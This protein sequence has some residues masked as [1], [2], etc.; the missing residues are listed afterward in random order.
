M[1][2]ITDPLF[3]V[4]AVPAVIVLGLA[5]GGFSGLGMIST[6]LL[7]LTTCCEWVRPSFTWRSRP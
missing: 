7:A 6:P 2:L 1:N 5:K 4:F 3:Y